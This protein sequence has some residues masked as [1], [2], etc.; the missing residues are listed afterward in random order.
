MHAPVVQFDETTHTS[1]EAVSR[2][3]RKLTCPSCITVKYDLHY[4]LHRKHPYYATGTYC[5][6]LLDAVTGVKPE[7]VDVLFPTSRGAKGCIGCR[8]R[9]IGPERGTDW[10]SHDSAE[11]KTTRQRKRK[12]DGNHMSDSLLYDHIRGGRYQE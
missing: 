11:E 5:C 3:T 10:G 2:A 6:L 7:R 1:D 8:G 12:E 9:E 4:G